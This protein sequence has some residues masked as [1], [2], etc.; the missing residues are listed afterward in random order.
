MFE[1]VLFSSLLHS[2]MDSLNE[3]SEHFRFFAK[4]PPRFFEMLSR[5]RVLMFFFAR[6]S[7]QPSKFFA[8][9]L[10]EFFLLLLL[11][12]CDVTKDSFFIIRYPWKILYDSS[13]AKKLD[14]SIRNGLFLCQQ[15][16]LLFFYIY[17]YSSNF[18]Y[19]FS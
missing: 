5:F 2:S 19:R 11:F 8:R 12:N 4:I 18:V 6:F 7:I 13:T 1:R 15:G 3:L 9:Y 16:S 10:V 14:R 17:I